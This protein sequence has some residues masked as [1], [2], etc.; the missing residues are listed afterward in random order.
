MELK[1]NTWNLLE[2]YI[3]FSFNARSNQDS[4]TEVL[5]LTSF[6]VFFITIISSKSRLH[7]IGKREAQGQPAV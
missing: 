4:T 3:F 6:K 5:N 7:K 2:I 1:S